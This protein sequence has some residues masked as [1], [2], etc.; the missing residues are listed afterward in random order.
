[1][2]NNYHCRRRTIPEAYF[3]MYGI[4]KYIRYTL[5]FYSG[6][7]LIY[8]LAIRPFYFNWGA[9]EKEVKMELP[10]DQW[11]SA[12]AVV[13][14]RAI[15]IRAD[16]TRVYPWIAQ[17][18]QNRGGFNSYTWLENLFGAE[19]V[20]ASTIH[21]EWQAPQPG[22]TVYYGKNQFYGLIS[23]TKENEYYAIG[24]WTFYIRPVG[25]SATRL[26]VRYPSMNVKQGGLNA[27]YYYCLF[28]PLHFTMETGMMMGIKK[29]AEK[30]YRDEKQNTENFRW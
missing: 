11:M 12:R 26:I 18:G 8:W 15:N 1:L 20:N 7:F 21:K 25:E 6:I 14:T 16:N 19:M 9:S 27:V 3:V 13:S 2:R 17:T 30:L 10:A 4:K 22:D 24:G 29:K 5:I 23:I 28:E